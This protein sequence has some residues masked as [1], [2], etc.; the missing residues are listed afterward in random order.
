MRGI[1]NLEK[2]GTL[3]RQ[4]LALLCRA[5]LSTSVLSHV[6]SSLWASYWFNN[7][8]P[9]SWQASHPMLTIR[10]QTV[11][12]EHSASYHEC[13]TP[14]YAQCA[15]HDVNLH[16]LCIEKAMHEHFHLR[17][18]TVLFHHLL[19]TEIVVS[20]RR[21]KIYR[22]FNLFLAISIYCLIVWDLLA[23]CSIS[24]RTFPCS[25]NFNSSQR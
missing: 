19:V 15:G 3:M 9:C 14:Y 16:W 12:E 1:H 7:L 13:L 10:G 23:I 6:Q 4:C 18:K 8:F 17:N 2:W 20:I 5:L 24:I 11:T 21:T 25:S 22:D